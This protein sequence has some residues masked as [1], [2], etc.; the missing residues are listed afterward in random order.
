[1]KFWSIQ[2]H[3]LIDHRTSQARAAPSRIQPR[4]RPSQNEVNLPQICMKSLK[5]SRVEES[6]RFWAPYG[7]CLIV[8]RGLGC[9]EAIN[10][11]FQ[12]LRSRSAYGHLR[13]TATCYYKKIQ[14][15]GDSLVYE[16]RCMRYIQIHTNALSAV[17]QRAS[18]LA[19]MNRDETESY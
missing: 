4:M 9:V 2:S 17:R 13:P 16:V 8:C 12:L 15:G 19:S 14:N 5:P 7:I 6:C 10:L 3:W 11:S 1:M 18:N